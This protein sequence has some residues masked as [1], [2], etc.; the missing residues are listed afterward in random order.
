MQKNKINCIN[1]PINPKKRVLFLGYNKKETKII[2]HLIKHKCYIDH[3]KDKID[4]QE[5]YDFLISFGY[6]HIL[7]KKVIEKVNCPIFNLH[8]SFLPYNRGAHPNFWSFYDKTPSG[9]SIHIIDEG[10][11]TGP[12]IYQK[13][14]NFDNGEKT[15]ANTYLTLIKE[16]ECLFIEKIENF[17]NERWESRP[18]K[19]NGTFHN[20]KDLPSNFSGWDSIIS[21]EIK[22]LYREGINYE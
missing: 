16:I 18:Q 7:K 8:I 4:F 19:G 2:D 17:I 10:I 14:V 6:K 9:V 1:N 12:I 13:Y 20:M 11:D 22:R 5:D 3:T 21:D 15:F